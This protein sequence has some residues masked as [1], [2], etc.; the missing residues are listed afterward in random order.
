MDWPR[1]LGEVEDRY[2]GLESLGWTFGG[3]RR[4]WGVSRNTVGIYIR[5]D[6]G[7]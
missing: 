3:P 4:L 5:W 7:G 2:G 6:I 1:S